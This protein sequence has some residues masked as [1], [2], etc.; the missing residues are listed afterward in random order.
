MANAELSAEDQLLQDKIIEDQKQEDMRSVEEE[1]LKASGVGD[2]VDTSIFKEAIEGG[3]DTVK[4]T[5][6]SLNAQVDKLFSDRD[7]NIID[8]ETFKKG[9][10][11]I[12]DKKMIF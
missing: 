12:N 8:G 3:T 6:D 10:N 11:V 4:K 5:V 9:L 1:Y 2:S 7:N